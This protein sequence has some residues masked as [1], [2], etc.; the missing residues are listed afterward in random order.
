MAQVTQ[1][2]REGARIW[3]QTV[4]PRLLELFTA[5][6]FPLAFPEKLC[7]IPFSLSSRGRA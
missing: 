3:T 1:L 4:W 7:S 6:P 5:A 2:A